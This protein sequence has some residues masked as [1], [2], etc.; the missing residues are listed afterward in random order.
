YVASGNLVQ[1]NYI[2]TD[3]TGTIAL[4]GSSVSVR[5]SFGNTIGGTTPGARNIISGSVSLGGHPVP[6]QIAN[7]VLQ[8]NYIGTDVTGEVALGGG[9]VQLSGIGSIV[10]GTVPGAGNRVSGNSGAR[11][12][13]SAEGA[14]P[15]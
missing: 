4:A 7:N 9:G 10:G 13:I 5:G 2:G 6:G 15:P 1:G 8:G 3:R 12:L 14:T 11:R